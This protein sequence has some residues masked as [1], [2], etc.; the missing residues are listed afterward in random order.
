[1]KQNQNK[2][3]HELNSSGQILGRLAAK[4]ADLLRG[5]GKSEFNY[6]ANV[7]DEVSVFNLGEIKVSG[8]KLDNKKYFSH[9]GY[10]GGLKEKSLKELIQTKP[11]L[12][13]KAAVKGMLPNN[14][15]RKEWLTQLKLFRGE[16][17]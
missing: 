11:E 5:K 7:G 15:L 3:K 10:P 17:K 1:M 4:T 16:I 12:V 14:K 6:R 9:S 13:F 2:E 8:R